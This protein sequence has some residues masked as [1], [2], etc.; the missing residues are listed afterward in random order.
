VSGGSS[1]FAKRRAEFDPRAFWSHLKHE[2][3]STLLIAL[4]WFVCAYAAIF[5]ADG[6][7]PRTFLSPDE[8]ANRFA[9]SLI[10]KTGR[11][12]LGLPFADP[13]D[14]LHP[15]AWISQGDHAIPIYPPVSIYFYALLTHLRRFGSVVL[16]SLP[17]SALAAIAGA[18]ASLL[19][20]ERRW[21]SAFAPALGMPALYWL[22]RPWMNLCALLTCVAFALFCWA[23][24]RASE[25]TAWLGATLF[26]LGL[27]AAARPDY[28]AYLLLVVFLVSIGAKPSAWRPLFAF[29][30]AAGALALAL[31]LVLN[32]VVTGHAFRAAYQMAMDEDP[33]ATKSSPMLRFAKLLFF[34][35]DF[36]GWDEVGDVFFRYWIGMQPAWLL[37]LG[38]LALIPLFRRQPVRTRVTTALV[39]ALLVLFMISRVDPNLFGLERPDGLVHDSIPRYWSP[40]YLLAGLPPLFFV[41]RAKTRP[42]LVAGSLALGGLAAGSLFEVVW[43][44]RQ[45]VLQHRNLVERDQGWLSQIVELVPREAI[46]YTPTYDKVVWSRF[47]VATVDKPDKTARSMLRATENGFPVYVWVNPSFHSELRSFERALERHDLALL[48]I[49]RPLRLYRVVP[50]AAA[51]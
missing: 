35:M 8:A 28:T 43:H 31:N 5:W 10:D 47:I 25:R 51:Q 7:R 42:L 17:A 21:L 26:L 18:V 9:S 38:Q 20:R 23:R 19:P 11:P 22:L 39:L 16:I 24:W 41:A 48:S 30:V 3:G 32:H 27:G 44:N 45:S 14:V 33:G 29:T 50:V 36:P 37:A 34:P 40:V 49:D 15:R 12:F 13:E 4:A 46:I 2:W 6:F 1:W